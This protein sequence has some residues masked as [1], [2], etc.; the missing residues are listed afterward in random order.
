[1]LVM[2]AFLGHAYQ[3]RRFETKLGRLQQQEDFK[4][5]HAKDFKANANE[6]RGWSEPKKTKL[7]ND[8]NELVRKNLAE[9]FA[10]ALERK[11]YLSEYRAPPIPKKM[12]LD[13]QYGVCFRACLAHLLDRMTARG[14]RDR[15]NIVIERGHTNVWDCERIFNDIK[16]RLLRIGIDL[17]GTFTVEA[18]ETCPPLMVGDFLAAFY[19]KLIKTD[20]WLETRISADMTAPPTRGELTFIGLRA[21]ALKNLKINFEKIRRMEIEEWRA[22]R[23]ARKASFLKKERPS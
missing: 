7:V 2:A 9:G 10:V 8:L 4:V 17:F 6:F 3:W 22:K 23:D 13:S 12:N 16:S 1:M 18:K 21:D 14:N 11:R 15:L 19:S 20:E 5:F